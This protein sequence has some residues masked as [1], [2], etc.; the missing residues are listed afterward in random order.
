MIQ[1]CLHLKRYGIFK[2]DLQYEVGKIRS[3]CMK[4]LSIV[5]Q[6]IEIHET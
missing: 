2:I 6:C 5:S 1:Q 4:L 3:M